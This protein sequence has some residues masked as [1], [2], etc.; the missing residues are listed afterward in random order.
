MSDGVKKSCERRRIMS[1]SLIHQDYSSKW[2]FGLEGRREVAQREP[3][4]QG[5]HGG[6]RK[7]VS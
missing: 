6:E 7:P 2:S 5:L 1:Q 4:P 3:E